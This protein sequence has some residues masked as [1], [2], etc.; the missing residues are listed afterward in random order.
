MLIEACER[1]RK[2]PARFHSQ[3]WLLDWYFLY[4]TIGQ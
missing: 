3:K 2:G 4:N 1:T